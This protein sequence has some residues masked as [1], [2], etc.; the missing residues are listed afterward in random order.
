[1]TTYL[2]AYRSRA[3][4]T[5][6]QVADQLGLQAPS[7]HKW[8]K[9]VTSPTLRDVIRLAEIYQIAPEAFFVDPSAD[10]EPTGS[11]ERL[12]VW[13]KIVGAHPTAWFHVHEDPERI[14]EAKEI[15]RFLE[16]YERL[17]PA[18][19]KHWLSVGETYP[20]EFGRDEGRLVPASSGGQR[21]SDFES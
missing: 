2:K 13:A 14:D 11:T 1:M 5:L 7:V 17:P 18:V 10:S 9:Q 6:Q 4:L 16:V 20:D 19:R 8:E 21:K 15:S 12:A 3:G